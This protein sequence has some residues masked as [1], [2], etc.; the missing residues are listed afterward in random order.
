[1][2]NI[3]ITGASSG[4]GRDLAL[5]FS[6]PETNIYLIGRSLQSLNEVK[7]ILENKKYNNFNVRIIQSDLTIESEILQIT[8]NLPTSI[9]LLIL[10]AGGGHFGRFSEVSIEDLIS[11]VKLNIISNLQLAHSLIKNL[12]K[13]TIQNKHSN[14]I[15]IS[16]H[17]SLMSVP[18]FAVYGACKSFLLSWARTL[19]QELKKDKIKVS[20]ILPGAMQ[21]KFSLRSN[22]PPKLLTTPVSTEKIAKIIKNKY[23]KNRIV[24]T[25]PIDKVLNIVSRLLPLELFD[26][27]ISTVQKKLLQKA[28][29]RN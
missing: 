3:V 15:I 12:K 8:Q 11:S 17:A 6:G 29:K 1:M 28:A 22:I 25:H 13:N 5:Q 16:S 18:H 27:L 21:S 7:N 19:N 9:S 24:I 26:N 10:N 20:V 23:S 2:R 14:I 4:L